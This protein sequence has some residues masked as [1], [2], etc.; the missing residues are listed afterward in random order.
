MMMAHNRCFFKDFRKNQRNK[1]KIVSRKCHAVLH[2]MMNY[3]ETR[4]KL[5]NTQTNKIK[6]TT[7]K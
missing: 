5:T 6:S 4:V 3:E 1:T 7:K 2:K